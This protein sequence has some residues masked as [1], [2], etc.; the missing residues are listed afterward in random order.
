LSDSLPALRKFATACVADVACGT[1]GGVVRPANP[2]LPGGFSCGAASSGLGRMPLTMPDR[3][4]V[5]SNSIPRSWA[6]RL[7]R[8]AGH[9]AA[10]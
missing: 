4:R 8:S 10:Q 7:R 3:M 6:R 1:L 2:S 5:L 9:R